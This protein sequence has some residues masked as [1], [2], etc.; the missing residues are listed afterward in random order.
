MTRVGVRALGHIAH[1]QMVHHLQAYLSYVLRGSWEWKDVLCHLDVDVEKHTASLPVKH[2]SRK[3]SR[4]R[5][6]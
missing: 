1:Y 4:F 5:S 2:K 6:P 3:A